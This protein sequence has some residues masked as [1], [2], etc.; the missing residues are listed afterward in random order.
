MSKRSRATRAR[1]AS[2]AASAASA[3]SSRSAWAGPALKMRGLCGH[4]AR[5]E[6]RAF[7]DGRAGQPLGQGMVVA[8]P[9][10]DRSGLQEAGAAAAA[11]ETERR[12]PQGVLAAPRAGRLDHLSK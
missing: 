2:L 1:S 8:G 6:A 12:Q 5:A 3:A 7:G 11:G 9:G 10:G 4:E